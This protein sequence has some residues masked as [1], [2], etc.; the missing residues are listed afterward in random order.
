M[1]SWLRKKLAPAP[2]LGIPAPELV[3]PGTSEREITAI[4]ISIENY[5]GIAEAVPLSRLTVF[6]NDYFERCGDPLLAEDI[7]IDKYV[8][9]TV[10]AMAGA[11]IARPDH[12]A[13][14]CAA[15]LRIQTAIADMRLRLRADKEPWPLIAQQ[16]RVRIGLNSGPAIVGNIGSRTRFNYTM[17][18]DSVNLAAR[19][20]TEAKPYGARIVCTET[21]HDECE[22]A[23]P[24]QILFRPLSF[25]FLKGKL[26]PIR[27]FEPMAFDARAT[28]ELRACIDTF[29]SALH[30]YERGA[31]AEAAA[32][33]RESALL[34]RDQT[35][36][37]AGAPANPSLY[38]LALAEARLAAPPGATPQKTGD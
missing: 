29:S 3:A 15:A 18:G 25:S 17:M 4:F 28:P 2:E 11:P 27:L 32:G 34:E 23:S 7:T 37:T 24:G 13:R 30:H 36:A 20:E 22:R 1:L 12:A 26:Q 33:F 10:V 8:G 6:M 19:L 14:S 21:T 35:T 31:W 16:L 5:V 9:D 38:F